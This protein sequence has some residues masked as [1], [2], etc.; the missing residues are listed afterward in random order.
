MDADEELRKTI[1][2]VK[3]KDAQR[4]ADAEEQRRAAQYQTTTE[5]ALVEEFVRT[6]LPAVVD[7]NLP[8][9]SVLAG[10]PVH[11]A[12]GSPGNAFHGDHHDWHYAFE[13]GR[14]EAIVESH[15]RDLE[16]RVNGKPYRINAVPDRDAAIKLFTTVVEKG[17]SG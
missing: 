11:T 6:I 12:A 14:A 17:L 2:A 3:R 13:I 4:Q 9:V 15:L 7:E 16:I 5:A 8:K 10:R 1:D